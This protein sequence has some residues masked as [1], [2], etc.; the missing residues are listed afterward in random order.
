[1]K[2]YLIPF[3]F[4]LTIFIYSNVQSQSIDELS[5]QHRQEIQ[6][7]RSAKDQQMTQAETSP[8]TP[9]QIEN[10]KGLSYF[11]IDFDFKITASFK[12]EEGRGSVSLNTSKGDKIE[13]I[14]YGTASFSIGEHSYSFSI[15]R[16]NNLPE[17][18][19]DNQILFIPFSDLTSGK[20]T[21]SG[22]RYLIV[23][24]AVEKNI[25]LDFNK[26]INPFVAYSS[27]FFSII[28]PTENKPS[29]TIETGERKFEDR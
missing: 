16:N 29:I 4:I 24:A 23:D 20:G 18:G 2:T 28:P 21:N 27:Q 9:S 15:F 25:I 12:Q 8:L 22:G 6:N 17:F 11:D 5:K 3:T 14:K 7:L 10:F 26:A 1:M 19:N 13:L